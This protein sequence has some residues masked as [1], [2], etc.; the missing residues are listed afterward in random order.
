MKKAQEEIRN[1]VRNRGKVTE[2]D[3]EELPHLKIIIKEKLRLH[4]PATLL[5]PKEIISHF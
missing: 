5:I 3:I 1:Y 2:K 4:P